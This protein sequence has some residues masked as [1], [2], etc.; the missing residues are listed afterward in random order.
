[1]PHEMILVGTWG[2]VPACGRVGG[3]AVWWHAAK[4]HE[5][6]PR[7][8]VSEVGPSETGQC[9]GGAREPGHAQNPPTA[10]RQLGRGDGVDRRIGIATTALGRGYYAARDAGLVPVCCALVAAWLVLVV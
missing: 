7:R 3:A 4:G 5:T 9:V 10:M 6:G 8:L 2:V 1:M